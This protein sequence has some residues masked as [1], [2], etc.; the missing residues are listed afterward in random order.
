MAGNLGPARHVTPCR[1]LSGDHGVGAL[2]ESR[3][4][5][6]E[7]P[8]GRGKTTTL[9]QLARGAGA[10]HTALMVDLSQW[11]DSGRNILE[12][13]GGMREFLARRIDAAELARVCQSGSFSFLLNGWNE[14]TASDSVAATNALRNLE[15]AFP[16][17]GII[18]ATR[19]HHLTPPLSAPTRLRLLP[20]TRRQRAEYLAA[21]LGGDKAQKLQSSLDAAPVLDELT[22]TPFIL[23]EVTRLFE[24]GAPIPKTK[25]G[26][27]SAVI[28]LQEEA[29]EH[30]NQL[31]DQPLFGMASAHLEA[32]A[33][34]MTRR[35][36]AS[37]PDTD[38]RAVI[39][40]VSADLLSRK[41]IQ[42]PPE[43]SDVLVALTAHHVLERTDYPAPAF[44]FGHQQF[45]E[46]YA[47][48][49]V[50]QRLLRLTERDSD[51]FRPFTAGYVNEPAWEEPLR[52]IAETLNTAPG[53]RAHDECTRAGR[54]LVEMAL[55][56]DPVFAG[57]LARACGKEVWRQ[58]SGLAGKRLRA[59]HAVD[60]G[61]HRDCALA[62]MLATGS[63][64]FRD[65]LISLLASPDQQVRLKT[66]RLWPDISVDSLGPDWR[67]EVASWPEDVRA[68]FIGD[69]LHNRSDP[70]LASFAAADASPR[71]KIA[72]ASGLSWRR[73]EEGLTRLLESMDSQTFDEF[74]RQGA[75]ECFPQGLRQR[76]IDCLWQSY[77]NNSHPSARLRTL[78]RLSELGESNLDAVL[79]QDFERLPLADLHKAYYVVDSVLKTLR[80]NDAEWLSQ[81]VATRLAAHALWQPEHWMPYVTRLPDGL[82]DEYLKRIETEDVKYRN[83][84]G[85]SALL[86]AY[87]DAGLAAQLFRKIRENRRAIV[88]AP[89]AKHEHE[90][91]V[92]RQLETLF[93]A[94]PGDVAAEGI[95]SVADPSDTSDLTLAAR[96]VSRAWR[97]NEPFF[98]VADQTL[99]ERLRTYL[100]AVVPALSGGSEFSR[101][102]LAH[103]AAAIAEVGRPEDMADIL[104]VLHADIDRRR[105][106]RDAMSYTNVYV[107]AIGRLDPDSSEKV[108]VDLLAVPEYT[109]EVSQ[110]LARGYREKPADVRDR[111]VR[112]DRMWAAREGR[113][114]APGDNDVRLR[115]AAALSAQIEQLMKERA[116]AKEPGPITWRMKEIAKELALID[117][118]G[119][120]AIVLRVLDIPSEWDEG[121]RVQTGERLVM[122]G[123]VLPTGIAFSI[124][125][126]AAG[127]V[128]KYGSQNGND[129]VL[130]SALSLLPFTD[131]PAKGIQKMR[132]VLS[133]TKLARYELRDLVVPLGESRCADA[134]D[135]LRDFAS[136][137]EAFKEVA[138]TW[139]AAVAKLGTPAARGL[140]PGFVDP[141]LK[142]LPEMPL[143]R[144][145]ALVWR[146]AELAKN[147]PKIAARL[148]ELCNKDLSPIKRELLA[149][150][151]SDVGTG[152]A[153][154]A[155]LNLIDDRSPRAIP[156]GTWEHI[157]AAF[158]QRR[159]RDSSEEHLHT[160]G[161]R[162]QRGSRGTLRHDAARRTAA[163]VCVQNPRP[164]R[165]MAS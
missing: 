3:R 157:E 135:L 150:V 54:L 133:Q 27:L 67:K 37:L 118:R 98:E 39:S 102:Q 55:G 48:I 51:S 46:Y 11:V 144:I 145:E 146:I 10:D 23:S 147:D 139:P 94:F 136:S 103:L 99:R 101:E 125:D 97:L 82:V 121:R 47:T 93:R 7:A 30:R 44:R 162:L 73:A 35:G 58:V 68:D 111:T 45:Q 155:N 64:D 115:H 120:S 137:P 75:A 131:D 113:L 151:M 77:K 164:D 19:T 9:V 152:E 71:V 16:E 122:G 12:Y 4:L 32:L 25:I 78:L 59:W 138:D 134:V 142:G 163:E 85:L 107:P 83:L 140:L 143:D 14:I 153:L 22:R 126:G 92:D 79:K 160:R 41:Q 8:A 56:V 42:R 110:E 141:D 60:D 96:L 130:K 15:R 53:D 127:K 28:R 159:R 80:K 116:Q 33:T 119:S 165:R 161:E 70:D 65:I 62:A 26:V 66:Y 63:S 90:W 2:R 158:V 81:W 128:R 49:D 132:E 87:G 108:L 86:A 29:Q 34:E 31:Q 38:A 148:C 20:L 112:Y 61:D 18:V 89:D 72:A 50:R 69:M 21:R 149:K 105:A 5:V 36:G 88:A 109:D 76:A 91:E 100:K 52:M 106:S 154:H 57:E 129:W 124:A 17:A 24:A 95:L 1:R 13:L 104:S 84:E 117:P 156:Q 114:P 74:V 6:L 43:P 123:A 40:A